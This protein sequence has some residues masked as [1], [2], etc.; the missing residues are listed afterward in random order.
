[1][2]IPNSLSVSGPAGASAKP[3]VP[4]YLQSF[5]FWF[6]ATSIR[7]FDVQ[8]WILDPWTRLHRTLMHAATSQTAAAAR[9][10][11]T[12]AQVVPARRATERAIAK[13]DMIPPVK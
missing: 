7:Q 1:L 13:R 9:A 12:M 4:A 3:V 8:I 5:F 2:D 6:S 10:S 11:D